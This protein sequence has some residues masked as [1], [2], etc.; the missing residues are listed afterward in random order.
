LAG[1]DAAISDEGAIRVGNIGAKIYSRSSSVFM[2]E[3][4]D[5][6]VTAKRETKKTKYHP[7]GGVSY[8]LG[9][10]L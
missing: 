9:C 2:Y 3:T 8:A 7:R 4:K 10:L 5:S 6:L 1:T